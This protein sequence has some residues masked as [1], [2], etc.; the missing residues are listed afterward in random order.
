MTERI[1]KVIARAGICS[2]RKAEDLITSGHVKINNLIVTN[3]ATKV[4]ADDKIKIDDHLLSKDVTRMWLYHKPRGLIT[5]HNDPGGRPTVFDNLPKTLPRVISIG[6]LD[7][8][9][10][11][12]LL[13]TNDGEVSRHLELPTNGWIR[14]YRAR[15][16][17]RLDIKQLES[18][19]KGITI[20]SIRYK[21][22]EIELDRHSGENSW[23]TIAITE[24]KNREI[25]K[26]FEHFGLQV[27][28]LIRIAYGPFQLD[29]L[30]LGM[31]KEVSSQ[32][33]GKI[34]K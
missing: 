7:F 30:A 17:G 8:N 20:D 25:R 5:S 21:P 27:N 4:S 15:V 19:K 34:I 29:D 23:L 32:S 9:T 2:R 18:L 13:L 3:C 10:E 31:V 11:G 16:Y 24:G 12:L 33:I 28:R 14:K 26:I 22:V 6:R 1:A